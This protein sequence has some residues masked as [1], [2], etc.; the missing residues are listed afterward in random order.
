MRKLGKQQGDMVIGQA[1]YEYLG[2]PYPYVEELGQPYEYLGQTAIPQ[3]I[4]PQR[5]VMIPPAGKTVQVPGRHRYRAYM[6]QP[7]AE[8][9]LAHIRFF[10][11][12]DN[13]LAAN[14]LA[15]NVVNVWSAVWTYQVVVGTML[16]FKPDTMNGEDRK[17]SHLLLR[18]RDATTPTA[19]FLRGRFILKVLTPDGAEDRVTITSGDLSEF[20]IG[21][22]LTGSLNDIRLYVTVMNDVWAK[23]GQFIQLSIN[24]PVVLSQANSNIWISA[25]EWNI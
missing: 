18:I 1:P 4:T 21:G 3:A 8:E 13:T 12:F 2:Q 9:E 14:Q 7:E 11:E 25:A 22:T 5:R 16:H 15:V 19:Q 24:S 23:Q 10:T 20:G 6:E 17:S